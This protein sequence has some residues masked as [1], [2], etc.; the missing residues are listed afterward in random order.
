MAS[1]KVTPAKKTKAPAKVPKQTGS[2]KKPSGHPTYAEM[3]VKAIV[4]LTVSNPRE[5]ASLNKVAKYITSSFNVG[6][7]SEA[8]IRQRIK[9]GLKK[10][11]DGEF[12][13]RK[14]GT[15]L[16]GSFRLNAKQKENFSKGKL[17]VEKKNAPTSKEADEKKTPVKKSTAKVAKP[18]AA[19]K[20]KTTPAKKASAATKKSPATKKAAV[21]KKPAAAKK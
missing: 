11:I 2:D 14:S 4:A 21:P 5:G 1:A 3:V 8:V 18:A 7:G 10:C 20:A 12:I 9:Q 19:P 13:T 16:T 6:A 17:F 15:G